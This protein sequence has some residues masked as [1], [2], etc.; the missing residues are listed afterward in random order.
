MVDGNI[1]CRQEN[2][3]IGFSFVD[4]NDEGWMIGVVGNHLLLKMNWSDHVQRNINAL[5]PRPDVIYFQ[6]KQDDEL[7]YMRMKILLNSINKGSVIRSIDQILPPST[8]HYH[9]LNSYF[10][11]Y[12]TIK[13]FRVSILSSCE[14]WSMKQLKWLQTI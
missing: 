4:K 1:I 3:W 2:N 6:T 12:S 14:F 10:T 7:S 11:Q 8:I 13:I 5:A 9:S